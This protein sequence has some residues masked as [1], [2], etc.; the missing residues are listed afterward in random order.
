MKIMSIARGALRAAGCAACL[1]LL[2]GCGASIPGLSTSAI[3]P[4]A[5]QN[6]PMSRALQVGSTA[7]RALKCG[8]NFD[9]VKLRT[10]FLAAEAVAAPTEA[11]KTGKIY[12]TAFNGI[13]KAV[14]GQGEAYCTEQKTADIRESLNRHLAG[15]Y[16][17]A[18]PKPQE[19]ED[20]GL[21]GGVSTDSSG[22]SEYSKKMQKNPREW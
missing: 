18:P 22:E 2:A 15:D 6:D 17:P 8:F 4:A 9:P 11:E 12:D 1:L 13:S 21:F 20:E 5:P 16:A 19:P 7:A 14:A 3:K 10:Q